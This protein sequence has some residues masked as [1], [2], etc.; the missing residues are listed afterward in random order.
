MLSPLLWCLVID[1]L[2]S[3]L[4]DKGFFAQKFA[5][6]LAIV[7]RGPFLDTLLELMQSVLKVTE[8]KFTGR[9][10]L[11]TADIGCDYFWM[12]R[13]SFG[14]TWDLRPGIV[15]WIYSAILRPVCCSGMLRALILRGILK[16]MKTTSIEAMGMLLSI[17]P[18][19]LI[20]VAAA[21]SAAYRLRCE[22]K[23]TGQNISHSCSQSA[24]QGV[25]FK[26]GGLALTVRSGAEKWAHSFHGWVQDRLGLKGCQGKGI[27]EAILLGKFATFF[28]AEIVA[29]LCYAQR[30][31]A[32]KERGRR[33]SIYSDSQVALKTFEA[34]IVNSKLNCRCTLRELARDNEVALVWVSGLGPWSELTRQPTSLPE[35]ARRLL[36]WD[37]TLRSESPAVWARG[38]SVAGCGISTCPW[39]GAVGCRQAK[40]LLGN[41]PSEGLI[42]CIKKVSRREA[43]L[44]TLLL[45]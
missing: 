6:D 39:R 30:L 45:I 11:G 13:R 18:L 38:R 12:Y 36:W 8:L 20:I 23:W 16:A 9:Y 7:V 28:Q 15:Y 35:L 40:A 42:S 21:A 43:G 37:R 29:I 44:M 26:A 5:D 32:D 34:L 31:L 2:L 33:I 17:E 10:K 4:N 25:L 41:V 27:N 24:V 14:Q 19:C 22:E 3:K 1:G